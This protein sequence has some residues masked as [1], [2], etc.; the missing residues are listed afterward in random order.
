MKKIFTTVLLSLP[1]LAM[2]GSLNVNVSGFGSDDKIKSNNNGKMQ[3]AVA[4]DGDLAAPVTTSDAICVGQVA[5]VSAEAAETGTIIKWY[6]AATG[7]TEVHVGDVYS[8]SGLTENL[9]VWAEETEDGCPEN[10]RTEVTITVN[11]LPVVVATVDDAEICAGDEVILTGTGVTGGTYTWNNDAVDGEAFEPTA[12]TTYTVTAEDANG[13]TDTDEITVTVT[14]A[15]PVADA[16]EDMTVCAGEEFHFTTGSTTQGVPTYA[17]EDVMGSFFPGQPLSLEA[18]TE[19]TLTATIG[20]CTATDVIVVTVNELP[21]VVAGASATEVCAGTE[22]TLTGSGA[23]EYVWNNDV[24]DGVAFVITETTTFEVTG[25]DENGCT[26]TEETTITVNELPVAEIAVVG[27]LEGCEGDIEVELTANTDTNIEWSTE[28]TDETIEVTVGGTYTLTVTDANGCE[29]TDEVTIVE[30]IVA[31]NL[32]EQATAVCT[33]GTLLLNADVTADSETTIMWN[34]NIA[35]NT[36]VT[37]TNGETYTV[38]AEDEFGCTATETITVS[39]TAAPVVTV[40]EGTAIAVCP[41]EEV[42]LTA[43][44]GAP[45]TWNNGVVNGTAFVPTQTTTYT[46]TAGNPEECTTEVDVVV[47]VHNAIVPATTVNGFVITATPAGMSYEWYDCAS[48]EIINGAEEATFTGVLDHS[49]KVVITNPVT[50]CEG[51]SACVAITSNAIAENTAELGITLFPNPTTGKVFVA[52]SDL[53]QVAV[54]NAQGALV[55]TFSNVQNGQSIDMTNVEAG[56]YMIHVATAKGSAVS[57]V[58]KN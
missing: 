45:Y 46:V 1:V 19:F 54:Y 11:A 40:T 21:V 38:V 58:V 31:I 16:G 13:C 43:V 4:C 25:T 41:G 42:T 56:I 55:A 6:N 33:G 44:S 52:T 17:S 15:T 2:A 47:T 3:A 29:G 39:V 10:A 30:H 50:G 57:R 12:T 34:E 7:G 37:P 32:E 23:E 26:A 5:E 53:V 9:T 18:S 14:T 20:A 36:E 51:T 24:E 27:D 49:Y 48:N 35:N 8:I 22:I 28:E